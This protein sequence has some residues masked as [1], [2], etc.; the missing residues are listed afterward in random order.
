[1][2][3]ELEG[4]SVL[5]SKAPPIFSQGDIIYY[6]IVMKETGH[7]LKIKHT[8]IP[9]LFI[10]GRPRVPN[11]LVEFYRASDRNAVLALV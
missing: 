6:K 5:S 11:L 10:E 7:F 8:A 2:Q 1:M 3:D 9:P 4:F